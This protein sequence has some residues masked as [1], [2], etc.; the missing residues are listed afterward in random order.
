[1]FA[2]ITSYLISLQTIAFIP[3]PIL[4]FLKALFVLQSLQTIAF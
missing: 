4:F 3:D 2:K 1:M